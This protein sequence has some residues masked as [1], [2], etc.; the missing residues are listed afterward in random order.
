VTVSQWNTESSLLLVPV[1]VVESAPNTQHSI[2]ESGRQ[3]QKLVMKHNYSIPE[4]RAQC[5]TMLL[6]GMNE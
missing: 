5:E 6:V 3:P 1:R 2:Q 4:S